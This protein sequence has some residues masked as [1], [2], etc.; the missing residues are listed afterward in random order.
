LKKLN[1]CTVEGIKRKKN[2][3]LA[4]R[5][6]IPKERAVLKEMQFIYAM[7]SSQKIFAQYPSHRIFGHI[8]G[9]LNAVEKNN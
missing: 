6:K 9:A 5:L 3:I 8:H 7:F 4:E 1:S 2:L